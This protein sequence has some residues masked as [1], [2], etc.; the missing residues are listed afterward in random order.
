MNEQAGLELVKPITVLAAIGALIV[1]GMMA[2]ILHFKNY[3]NRVE[4]RDDRRT[5][6]LLHEQTQRDRIALL[7]MQREFSAERQ[8][9]LRERLKMMGDKS[10]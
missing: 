6:E 4:A 8:E 3:M 5:A 1:G 2:I 9:F 7:E 10:A